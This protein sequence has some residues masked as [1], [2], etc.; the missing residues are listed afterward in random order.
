MSSI[1]SH[2]HSKLCLVHFWTPEL[3]GFLKKMQ[4]V[5]RLPDHDIGTCSSLILYAPLAG[6]P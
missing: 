5:M 1:F 4:I 2:H 6:R 3:G